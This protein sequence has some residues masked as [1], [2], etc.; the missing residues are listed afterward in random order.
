MRL[1][2]ILYFLLFFT[3][4]RGEAQYLQFSQY[5]FSRQ[6]VSPARVGATDYASAAYI[7]RNQ[8]E[9]GDLNLHSSYLEVIYPLISR[10]GKR[11]S[12]LG[13]SLMDD[14]YGIGGIYNLQE[15]AGTY[16]LHL[17]LTQTQS[18]SLGFKGLFHQRKVNLD[19]F[20]TGMQYIPGRGFDVSAY[21]GEGL[22]HLK[23]GFFTF[24]SGLDWKRT[25]RN[26]QTVAYGSISFY[27]FNRPDES[28]FGSNDR[29]SSTVIASGGVRIQRNLRSYFTPEVL[30]THNAGNSL[31]NVGVVTSY[32]PGTRLIS[33]SERLDIITKYVIGRSG[34]I[35]LQWHKEN[36]SFGMSYDFP[37]IVKNYGN[38]GTLEVALEL[39]QL[40]DRSPLS[41][42]KKTRK[43]KYARK[44]EKFLKEK[45]KSKPDNQEKYPIT[46]VSGQALTE[47]VKK[48]ETRSDT[49]QEKLSVEKAV[50]ND[51][52][53]KLQQKRDSVIASAVAG[54]LTHQPL[55]LEKVNLHFN[56]KLNSSEL[57]SESK[58]YLDELARTLND[59]PE[60]R[61]A[62][63]GHTDNTG[64]AI[65][66]LRLSRFR[67]QEIK[68]YLISALVSPERISADGKGLAEPLNNNSNEEERAANRRVELLIIYDY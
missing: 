24:S 31:I 45:G 44:R 10:S 35:G 37:V 58:A 61:I 17:D 20:Y 65:Y 53:D 50:Q 32:A 52:S 54:K 62:L 48:E 68:E 33:T 60:L 23:T 3:L 28:F 12:G 1:F 19:G 55:V 59:N 9:G 29:L 4:S 18:L 42:S 49:S 41:K 21:S 40:V 56:F 46:T 6:R 27:D 43:S 5:N 39:R 25:D 66:N 8:G 57:D 51:F 38:T 14:R 63:T 11:W 67:A 64:S 34:I 16:A 15:V 13:L 22:Q 7:Y 26:G 2:V 30:Y 47:V 36:I